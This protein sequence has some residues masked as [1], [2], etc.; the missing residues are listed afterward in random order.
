MASAISFVP[1]S[2]MGE[3]VKQQ[4]VILRGGTTSA[5]EPSDPCG[6][7]LTPTSPS[8]QSRRV[9]ALFHFDNET[10]YDHYSLCLAATEGLRRIRDRR[11]ATEGER[12]RQRDHD[13]KVNGKILYEA[14]K[15]A[16]AIYVRDSSKV[17]KA[18]GMS[19]AEFNAIGRRV[20]Q[21]EALKE[22][23]SEWMYVRKGKN[24]YH[25][26]RH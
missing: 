9:P 24:L 7:R 23:V 15:R 6:E 25:E 21:D 1:H 3:A 12:L 14:E 13:P 5:S 8:H 22:K 4:T 11:I 2:I 17:L 16:A 19:V 26:V 10:I 18:M 20:R